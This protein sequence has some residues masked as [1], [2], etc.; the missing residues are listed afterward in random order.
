MIN[1]INDIINN[2]N[3]Y[4]NYNKNNDKLLELLVKNKGNSQIQSQIQSQIT[5]IQFRKQ[6]KL[7]EKI[8]ELKYKNNFDL[9]NFKNIFWDFSLNEYKIFNKDL[10]FLNDE[11]LIIHFFYIGRYERRIYNSKIKII[12]VCNSWLD[13]NAAF[14]NGGN[15][16]LYNLGK[17][18]NERNYKNIYAK[19][20]VYERTNIKNPLCNVFANDDEINPRTLVIYSDG[21]YN[22]ILFAR[23]VMRWILLEIGTTYRP[24]DIVNS[25]N[26]DDLV[27]HWEK[28]KIAKNIKILNVMIINK[29][30]NN[31]YLKRE[32]GMTCYLIKKR[33]LYNWDNKF[34]HKKSS[35]CIDDL[36]TDKIVYN[37]NKC[38]LFYCYDLNTFLIIGAIICGCK[39]IL[40]PDERTKQAYIDVSVLSNFQKVN[41]MIAW[42]ENDLE[43]INY[44][45]NDIIELIKFINTLSNSVDVFLEDIYCYFNSIPENIPR[46]KNVYNS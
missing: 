35:I 1:K 28:S 29:K 9:N 24:L 20:Y 22:N 12:I 32:E 18:I 6:N 4:N 40:V 16:A 8:M 23:N 46:V 26:P 13:D 14:G 44:D 5:L 38:K 7:K 33:K 3:N 41:S 37:F 15:K 25:W 19:M 2:D 11:E 45:E 17:I 30:Y 39:V 10:F 42:G 27:Y 43:N 36:D 34:I 21:T 31:N